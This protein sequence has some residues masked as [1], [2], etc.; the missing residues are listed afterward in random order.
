LKARL[1]FTL[2]AALLA[3]VLFLLSM[4]FGRV[5]ALGPTFHPVTGVLAGRSATAADK[6]ARL[7]REVEGL[8]EPVEIYYT[9]D[10]VPLIFAGNDHDLYFAQGYA[11]ARDRLFQLEL[12]VRAAEGSISEWL[13]PDRLDY[14]RFMRRMGMVYGAENALTG[15]SESRSL[16]VMQAYADGIN[17]W[18]D[19]LSDRDLPV[20]YK[21]IGVR[22]RHWQPIHSALFLKYMTRTL[23][24]GSSDL[25]TSNA[26]ARFGADFVERYLS[27]RGD[28]TDPIISPDHRW[29][30]DPLPVQAPSEPFTP[31]A[32]LE[33]EPYR[34][35]PGIGSNNWAVSGSRTASGNP[36]LAGDPHLN[37]TLPSI[38]YQVQLTAPGIR[39]RGVSLPGSPSVI[40]GFTDSLAWMNTNTGADIVDWYE[41]RYRDS[42]LSEYLYDGEWRPVTTR[43]EEI[44]QKDGSVFLDTIRFTHHGPVVY[45]DRF[46][47]SGAGEWN[48][49]LAMRWIGHEPS[50]ESEVY[51]RLNRGASMDD[52]LDALSRFQAPA[53]N[54]AVI[55]ASGNIGMLVS[56]R[57]PL[58]WEG[59]GATIGDGSSPAYDWQGWIPYDHNPREINP[60]RGFVSSANQFV[61]AESY[62]YYLG[63][64][65]APFERGRRANDLLKADSAVTLEKMMAMQ[66]DD[67]NYLAA[68]SL[69][70]MLEE[71]NASAAEL[72]STGKAALE[73]LS[74][75]DYHNQAERIAPSIFDRLWERI[76]ESVWKDDY[77]AVAQPMRN[78]KRDLTARML[79]KE[80]DA[81]YFDD[82]TT[83]A[84]ES[85]R[86]IVLK[87]FRAALDDLRADVGE[88]P[89]TWV[90]GTAS[91]VSIPHLANTRGLGVDTIFMGGGDQT[92]NAVDR[93]NGPS[94]R[95]VLEF[96]PDGPRAFGIYPGGQSGDPGSPWYDDMVSDWAEGSWTEL[97]LMDHPGEDAATWPHG[98]LRLLP[99]IDR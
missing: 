8:L 11:T 52:A 82:I 45:D 55:D 92:L 87:A 77:D 85:R 47:P 24:G 73:H 60:A 78:P 72:D 71:L 40:M 37:L 12:Q 54:F 23:A 53:Q 79:A 22:P 15:F 61:T 2:S 59:Q 26:I 86:D 27:G 42:T 65:F 28:W 80:P 99:K 84:M 57:F 7:D 81:P 70:A 67:Y 97:P 9:E 4:P 25:T 66:L 16:T 36:M 39:V 68:V 18:I 10:R 29:D 49:G 95:M 32:T 94:W 88:D 17:A 13:G 46:S 56:G 69:P 91:K 62:P 58:K 75:W 14:D 51:Y 50:D 44:R 83:E 30:F 64:R 33:V 76:M 74:A 48:K 34:P 96:T 3:G 38:W 21:L 63:D 20:E 35:A 41:I 43:I 89:E 5:P 6:Q 31:S 93:S 90:W 19:G 1:P 98:L